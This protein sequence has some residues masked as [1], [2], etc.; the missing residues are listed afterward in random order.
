MPRFPVGQL[1]VFCAATALALSPGI[2]L[3]GAP[4][5]SEAAVHY[6]ISGGGNLFTCATEQLARDIEGSFALDAIILERMARNYVA[7][8]VRD[9]GMAGPRVIEPGALSGFQLEAHVARQVGQ[10]IIGE[11]CGEPGSALGAPLPDLDC[12]SDFWTSFREGWSAHL[13]AVAFDHT[14]SPADAN[15]QLESSLDT[16]SR[17]KTQMAAERPPEPGSGIAALARAFRGRPGPATLSYPLWHSRHAYA[18]RIAGTRSAMYRW[19]PGGNLRNP[20]EMLAT[21]GVIS[22]MFYSL[23]SDPRVQY[24]YRDR[25]FYRPFLHT[26][27]SQAP[28]TVFAPLHNA[29]AKVFRVLAASVSPGTVMENRPPAAVFISE[30][31]RMFP[32][33]ADAAFDAFLWATGG[34]TVDPELA[35]RYARLS[36]EETPRAREQYAEFLR[37]LRR[38]LISGERA[39]DEAVGPQL[40]LRSPIYRTGLCGYDLFQASPVPYA[41]DLNA[42]DAGDL[43]T[44][45]GMTPEI[46]SAI[47]SEREARVYFK[48]IQELAQVKGMSPEILNALQK[49]KSG[50]EASLEASGTGRLWPDAIGAVAR[51]YV[52]ML[53]FRVLAG[54]IICCGVALVLRGLFMLLERRFFGGWEPPSWMDPEE[55]RAARL[56]G[57]LLRVIAT[58]AALAAMI[59][60]LPPWPRVQRFALGCATGSLAWMAGAFPEIVGVSALAGLSR[61]YMRFRVARSLVLMSLIAGAAFAVM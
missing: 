4:A 38:L 9:K 54:L 5:A 56:A 10:E 12:K 51:S 19:T 2:A 35:S 30:Y 43:M 16:I 49:A 42:A 52:V 21:P 26:A 60:I 28:E 34:A 8:T 27:S 47:L 50:M 25:E 58:S 44:V 37:S 13:E 32:D 23:V 24:N 3:A 6:C 18:T 46:A 33:E 39:P 48:T 14:R 1:A 57:I 31:A 15:C 29:Y 7:N 20:S 40:W 53:G 61:R 59:F 17:W 55:G 45:P 36:L 22:A 41:F 11:L